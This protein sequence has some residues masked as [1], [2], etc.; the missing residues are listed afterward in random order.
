MIKPDQVH[1][2]NII[3]TPFYNYLIIQVANANLV[4]PYI[5]IAT[6]HILE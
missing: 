2:R 6:L 3:H 1:A 4:T 5:L